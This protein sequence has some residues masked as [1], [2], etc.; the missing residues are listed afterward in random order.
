MRSNKNL[1]LLSRGYGIIFSI[2]NAL[3]PLNVISAV[4]EAVYPFISIYMGAEI[5]NALS[6]G[7]GIDRIYFL[8]AATITANFITNQIKQLITRVLEQKNKIFEHKFQMFLNDKTLGMDYGNIEN[9]DTHIKRRRIDEIRN[10]GGFGIWKLI[11]CGNEAVTH[12]FTVI[13][14]VAVTYRAFVVYGS[15]SQGGPA[16]VLLSPLCSVLLLIFMVANTFLTIYFNAKGIKKTHKIWDGVIHHNRMIDYMLSSYI[17]VYQAGKDIRLYNQKGM[18]LGRFDKMIRDFAPPILRMEHTQS[19]YA[20]VNTVLSSVVGLLVYIFIGVKALFKLIGLGDLF[21]YINGIAKFNAGLNGFLNSFFMLRVNNTYI[22][23]LY[24]FLDIPDAFYQGTLTTEKRADND[25]QIEFRNVS[26]KYPGTD[27]Y[28]LKNLNMKF[29]TGRRM[30]VVGVN[31]SGKT[32]MI[33]LLCRLY[34]PTEGEITLNGIDIKKYDYAEYVN[35]F[36][37]VFQDFKLFSFPLSQNAASSV[38]YDRGK[39]ERCLGKAGFKERLGEMPNGLDTPLYKD[40]E[41]DG[42]EISGGE[43]QK[44]ALARALYKDA[45][46]IVLDEPTAALDPIAEFEVYSKFNEIV[47]NKTAVY[48]SHRLSSCRFCDDIAVFNEGRL[49]QRGNHETLLAEKNGKYHELWNAQAQ[50]YN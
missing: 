7:D 30:A 4:L 37:V 45:P 13:T 42:V 6:Q 14:S 47:G 43:A 28:A 2:E 26:F 21:K 3:I 22:E 24:E 29:D 32:T 12:L 1:Q 34:D 36:S 33:K 49:I 38:E 16:G 31:G 9:P 35:I 48:I 20:N 18:I 27:F 40:F 17:N 50:Y 11:S 44:I 19:Q 5:L 41:E 15:A 25:Y 23:A 39:V 46:F 10:M 8:L